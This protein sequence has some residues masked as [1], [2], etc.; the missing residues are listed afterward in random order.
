MF[1]ILGI[2]LFV[3]S[4]SQG[5]GAE[6]ALTQGETRAA[7]LRKLV[8]RN[9]NPNLLEGDACR[10]TLAS[11]G[12]PTDLFDKPA[13]TPALAAVDTSEDEELAAAL[14]LSLGLSAEKEE[15]DASRALAKKLERDDSLA[16]SLALAR[17]IAKE[18]ES[19]LK[20]EESGA[21]RTITTKTTKPAPHEVVLLEL[22]K[23][24]VDFV[25]AAAGDGQNVHAFNTGYLRGNLPHINQ[26]LK[27]LRIAANPGLVAS[28]IIPLARKKTFKK[29]NKKTETRMRV[30]FETYRG[31]ILGILPR[32]GTSPEL[33][34]S[35]PDALSQ[36]YILATHCDLLRIKKTFVDF[37]FDMVAQNITEAGG[38]DDGIVGRA[39]M[40][41][42]RSAVWL[43]QQ[44]YGIERPA[45]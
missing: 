20:H 21:R 2:L 5:Y 19:A 10:A 25:K 18:E 3:F 16:A 8:H 39:M 22:D 34:I 42:V 35:I 30:D 32:T 37:F 15:E 23:S 44:K 11:L 24:I 14:A 6:D 9:I 7:T 12:L 45:E 27:D 36:A 13:T 4:F 17:R 31:Y 38:C 26:C 33:G 41:C 43:I 28:T 29:D 1:R 40:V